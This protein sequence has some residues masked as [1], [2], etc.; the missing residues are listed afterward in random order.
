VLLPSLTFSPVPASA[1]VPAPAPAQVPTLVPLERFTN[2]N[3]I[4]DRE[5]GRYRDEDRDEDRVGEGRKRGKGVPDERLFYEGALKSYDKVAPSRLNGMKK[6]MDTA[7]MDAYVDEAKKAVLVSIRGTYDTTDLKADASLPINRLRET[8]RYRKDVDEFRKVVQRYSPSKYEYYVSGHS[9]GG[10][11]LMLLKRDFPFIRYGVS[12]NSAYQPMDIANEDKAVKKIYTDQDPLYKLG[13]RLFKTN[14]RVIPS[15]DNTGSVIL[16]YL[17]GVVGQ[18][19]LL[20]S[21]VGVADVAVRGYSGHS[22]EGFKRLYY[23]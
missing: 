9:L 22:L 11:V 4:I 6:V 5:E 20:S 13:G 2:I 3:Q 17:K 16:N 23:G 12:Y 15:T 18:S 21:L 14:V 1:P 7:T 8:Q 10:A 19:Q